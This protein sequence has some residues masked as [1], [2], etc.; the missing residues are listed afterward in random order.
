M[1]TERIADVLFPALAGV[2]LSEALCRFENLSLI[3]E[4]ILLMFCLVTTTEYI[5][6]N[7]HPEAQ[8]GGAW[9]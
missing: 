7:K 4:L 3:F 1:G 8:A 9:G 2:R 6:L 5:F